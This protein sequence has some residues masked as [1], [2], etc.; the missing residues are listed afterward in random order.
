MKTIKHYTLRLMAVAAIAVAFALPAKAQINPATYYNVDWQFNV[1]LGNSFAG[2][3]SGWGMNF[4][5]GCYPLPDLAVGLFLN[6]QTNNE[7]FSRRTIPVSSTSVLTTDQQH[8]L[9]QLPFGFSGHYRFNDGVVQP[10]IGLKLGAN[11]A[12]MSSDFSVY[13]VRDKTWGFYA[14]PE[15]GMRI[16]PW[17]NGVGLHLAAYYSYATNQGTVFDYHINNLTNLGFRL[18]VAF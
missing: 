2:K 7:Y 3:A 11:Y 10:Y 8:S 16:Y 9:F 13:E 12:K 15:V 5:A 17:S 4:E 14:S 1:P 6:Y 18:G